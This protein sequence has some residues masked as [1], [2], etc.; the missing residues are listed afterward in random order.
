M[1]KA[2]ENC[3]AVIST[4]VNEQTSVSLGEP[5]RDTESRDIPTYLSFCYTQKVTLENR[6]QNIRISNNIR[7][8]LA[9]KNDTSY[10]PLL[11]LGK[12]VFSLKYAFM[13]STLTWKR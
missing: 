7:V 11:E 2:S 1:Y 13:H 5:N 4:V 6:R 12:R 3:K 8:L 10:L 9:K